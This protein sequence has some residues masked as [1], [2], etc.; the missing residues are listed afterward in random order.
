MDTF[1][2][3]PVHALSS[4]IYAKTP[5]MPSSALPHISIMYTFP[6][7]LM[8]N[9]ISV[10][11]LNFSSVRVAFLIKT[12]AWLQHFCR[13]AHCNTHTHT[14]AHL[15]NRHRKTHTDT[16]T[17]THPP[18]T[19]THTQTL[20]RTHINAREVGHECKQALKEKNYPF[21]LVV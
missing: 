17:L 10:Q 2:R 18:H 19:H 14:P 12:C 6:G 21:P 15:F 8:Y 7:V 13:H 4:T 20:G 3:G 5:F 1:S 16:P 11:G 9:Q